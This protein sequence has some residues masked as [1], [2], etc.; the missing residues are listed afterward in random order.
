[1][2][3]NLNRHY[4]YI[5]GTLQYMYIYM[6]DC[7]YNCCDKY[8]ILLNKYSKDFKNI[9]HPS[10][11]KAN[12][13]LDKKLQQKYIFMHILN[14]YI[15]FSNLKDRFLNILPEHTLQMTYFNTKT[16]KTYTLF[17]SLYLL[18]YYEKSNNPHT[19]YY[20]ITVWSSKHKAY[21]S[22]YIDSII[23]RE[24]I[25]IYPS[26]PYTVHNILCLLKHTNYVQS[27]K[28]NS[29]IY[30]PYLNTEKA[31]NYT[32]APYF[33]S[34]AIPNNITVKALYMLYIYLN[35]RNIFPINYPD[36]YMDSGIEIILVHTNNYEKQFSNND[37]IYSSN[38]VG[39]ID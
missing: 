2:I 24:L 7:Y 25:Y 5:Y 16:N 10:V 4:T 19:I 36:L 18:E 13:E 34:F 33:R 29:D 35:N 12:Y 37:I 17:P 1:M 30:N 8:T 3:F 39:S 21:I 28:I 32:L 11:C 14:I 27:I 26:N 9:I 31:C 20:N 22:L 6:V 23:L 38:N 15:F